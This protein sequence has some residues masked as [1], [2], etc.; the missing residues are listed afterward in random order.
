MEAKEILQVLPHL[1]TDDKLKILELALQLVNQEE[2]SLTSDEQKRLFAAAA[3]TA[4]DDYAEGSELLV[5]SE[6]E[7]EDFCDY[8][9]EQP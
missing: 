2:Q 8:L 6:I 5:F 1:S 4:K 3:K 7:G 9:E